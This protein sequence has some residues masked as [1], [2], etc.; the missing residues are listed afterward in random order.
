[1][2]ISL[3]IPADQLGLIWSMAEHAMQLPIK[4]QRKLEC[5]RVLRMLKELRVSVLATDVIAIGCLADG[6]RGLF[7]LPQGK[8]NVLGGVAPNP[9]AC[10]GSST[11]STE[12]D[13]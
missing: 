6:T 9:A 10:S 2:I 13:V 1:M 11:N 12:G 5:Q 4:R 7:L 8:T 3:F